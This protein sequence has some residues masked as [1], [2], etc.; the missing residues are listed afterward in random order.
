MANRIDFKTISNWESISTKSVPSASNSVV[1]MHSEHYMNVDIF[2]TPA[3]NDAWSRRRSDDPDAGHGCPHR[4]RRHPAPGGQ[5]SLH[6]QIQWAFQDALSESSDQRLFLVI[7]W[8][9][10][11]RDDA[12]SW[13]NYHRLDSIYSWMDRFATIE[14]RDIWMRLP[15]DLFQYVIPVPR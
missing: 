10:P 12:M 4:P 15:R 13:N 5:H 7:N 9:M 1:R 8:L 2:R 11:G 14:H 3:I 6:R